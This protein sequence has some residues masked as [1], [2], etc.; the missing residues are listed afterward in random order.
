M[1]E[2]KESLDSIKDKQGEHDTA[3]ALMNT[4]FDDFVKNHKESDA[5]EK[6]ERKAAWKNAMLMVGAI[7]TGI[8][9]IIGAMSALLAL[10]WG[11]K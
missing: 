7:S 3:I 8:A 10:I 4:K 6:E 9:S 11:N 5:A 1:Q 2:I